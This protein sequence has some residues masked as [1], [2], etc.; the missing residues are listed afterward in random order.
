MSSFNQFM[1]P[2]NPFKV[3][4]D[5]KFLA[6]KY[7]SFKQY[8]I[9]YSSNK[10]YKI[11]FNDA[12]ALRCLTT[13]LLKDQFNLDINLPLDRLIPSIPQ[14][15]NY[16][17]WLD[18]ILNNCNF[19]SLKRVNLIDCG[20]GASCVFPLVS[21]QINKNWHFLATELDDYSLEYAK[22][23]CDLNQLSSQIKGKCL[24]NIV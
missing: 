7:P 3:K 1:H 22:Q 6:D 17:L 10:K 2:R 5:Y 9:P 23:N 14:R 15:L 20:T 24:F 16:I 4:P 19:N 11:N 8:L 18:D 12:N 13:I 21:I